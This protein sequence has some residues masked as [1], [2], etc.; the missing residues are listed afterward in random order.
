MIGEENEIDFSNLLDGVNIDDVSI[1]D[2]NIDAQN[3]ILLGMKS[4]YY[5][6]INTSAYE[7]PEAIEKVFSFTCHDEA[8]AM[9]SRDLGK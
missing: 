6:S 8:R 4:G 9:Q 2:V 1:D 5:S 7:S 3:E